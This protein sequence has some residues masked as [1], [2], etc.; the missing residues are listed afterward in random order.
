MYRCSAPASKKY[1]ILI[2]DHRISRNMASLVFQLRV[3]H[4]PLNEYLY[5]FGKVASEHCP[6]CG[7]A[8]ETIEHFLPH[9]PKYAHER[10]ALL[11][12]IRDNSPRLVDVLSNPKV[13]I[14]TIN[15]IHA[16]ER[17]VERTQGQVQ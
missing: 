3:G 5:R 4:A 15:Y 2:S 8:K 6:A 17:F 16:M 14:S 12:N 10:W 9:C 13:I 1:L 11:R 7:E